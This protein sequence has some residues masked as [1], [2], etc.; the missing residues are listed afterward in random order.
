MRGAT[1]GDGRVGEDVTAEL[2]HDR[3]DPAARS[4]TRPRAGR[5]ARRGLPA[6]RRLRGAE[7]APRRRRRAGLRQPAQ[8]RRRLA[9]PARP[10][11]HRRRR[12]RSAA[13]RSAT[14]RASTSPPTARS[15]SGCARRLPGQPRHRRTTQGIEAVVG[16]AARG[17]RAATNSTTRSTAP[18][19]RSTSSPC[20][21]SWARSAATRAGRSPTS[22]RRPR[23]PRGC[24]SI[25]LTSGAPA[26]LMPFAMLEPVLVGGVTV[27]HRHPA[28]RG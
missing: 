16:A 9:P 19:S 18:W 5:G 25:G 7:R 20:G 28:Q 6:D 13:T 2:A 10:E 17:R 27:S 23:R 14:P 24:T 26:H 3:L 1:R 11:A 21:V 15:S 8:R 22:S 4:T 12:S